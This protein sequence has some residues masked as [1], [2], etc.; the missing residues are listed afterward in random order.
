MENILIQSI[1]LTKGVNHM[2][3][4]G[5][6]PCCNESVRDIL[7][8]IDVDKLDNRLLKPNS[9]PEIDFFLKSTSS[10]DLVLANL[11]GVGSLNVIEGRYKD[12]IQRFLNVIFKYACGRYS[13]KYSYYNGGYDENGKLITSYPKDVKEYV[14]YFIEIPEENNYK[15]KITKE[16]FDVLKEVGVKPDM[17][18]ITQIVVGVPLTIYKNKESIKKE[19][20]VN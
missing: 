14:A 1:G 5:N 10:H 19:M 18:G 17:N 2:E 3:K 7:G 16:L 8:L 6:C 20:V 9:N 12:T 11:V 4:N 13:A 15:E